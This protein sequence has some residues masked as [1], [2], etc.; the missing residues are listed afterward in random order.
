M[1]KFFRKKDKH[2]KNESSKFA[3]NKIRNKLIITLLVVILVPL[4]LLGV[5]SYLRS[6]KILEEKLTV[7]ADQSVLNA[8]QSVE[9]YLI[10]FEK[11]ISY[12]IGNININDLQDQSAIEYNIELFKSIIEN[13][14]AMQYLY[15]GTKNKDFYIY[16]QEELPSDYDPTSRPWYQDAINNKGEIIWTKP[17]ADAITQE[18]VITAAKAV[19]KNGEVIGVIGADIKL[20]DFSK[21]MSSISIGSNGYLVMTD[22]DG[23]VLLHKNQEMFGSNL[24]QYD[25]WEKIN[26]TSSGSIKYEFNEKNNFVSFTTNE[27][28]GWKLMGIIEESELKEDTNIIKQFI[29]IGVV[30]GV[31]I[32]IIFAFLIARWIA[33]PISQLKSAFSQASLGDLNVRT[34]IKSKDEFGDLGNSFNE[35]LHNISELIDDVK[36]NADESDLNSQLLS[37]SIQEFTSQVNIINSSTQEIAIGLEETS[38]SIEEI[39]SGGQEIANITQVLAKNATEGN[40]IA[41]EIEKRATDIKEKTSESASAANSIYENKQTRVINAIEQGKVVAEISKMA[42]V[43]SDVAEQTNLLALNAAIEAARAGEH[44]RGFAVV[45]DEVRKLAEQ[46]SETVIEIQNIVV[47]VENA[48]NYLAENTNELLQ[49]INDKVINDY[50]AFV[51]TGVQYQNDADLIGE[52]FGSFADKTEQI[53]VSMGQIITAIE[54]VAATSDQS[55]VSTQEISNNTNDLSLAI[56]EILE[57]SNNQANIAYELNKQIKKFNI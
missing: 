57:I 50:K 15:F 13:D 33:N 12:T 35:M 11:K 55:A 2:N 32:G 3:T 27:R 5:T 1:K 44:G 46:S 52:L 51:E 40:K 18:L 20:N 6:F 38:A 30:V 22:N 14:E 16:P 26:F 45:A 37:G 49:F 39:S 41:A 9:E 31:I 56:A 34:N 43:I 19:V 48:F 54:S 10:D 36:K 42:K 28:T 53:A 29:I 7:I 8:N 17:Y 4:L 23:T 21:K 25:Y 47:D 24:S